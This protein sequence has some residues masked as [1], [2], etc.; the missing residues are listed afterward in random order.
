MSLL[1]TK[2][3]APWRAV[4]AICGAQTRNLSRPHRRESRDKV[5][6][7][8]RMRVLFCGRDEF[9]CASLAALYYTKTQ[10]RPH[11]VIGLPYLFHSIEV[12]F[13]QETPP[14]LA[15]QSAQGPPIKLLASQLGLRTH[16]RYRGQERNM[17]PA[18]DLIIA[19]FPFRSVPPALIRGARYGGLYLHPSMLPEFDGP[20]PFHHTLLHDHILSTGVTVEALGGAKDGNDK[21][22]NE[23]SQYLTQH[24]ASVP[25]G[26]I[27]KQLERI[28]AIKG[29]QTLLGALKERAHV[30]GRLREQNGLDP[31][32]P[33]AVAPEREIVEEFLRWE[34]DR[35]QA[36]A[37]GID[38]RELPQEMDN[39]RNVD[40][41]QQILGPLW[42]KVEDSSGNI[43]QIF[44]EDTQY[45][46]GTHIKRQPYG[47]DEKDG[48]W[49]WSHF[50]RHLEQPK[51]EGDEDKREPRFGFWWRNGDDSIY[52][53]IGPRGMGYGNDLGFGNDY[54]RI[55]RLR[56]EGREPSSAVQV[57]RPYI[58]GEPK[59]MR[60]LLLESVNNLGKTSGEPVTPNGA[61]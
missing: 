52:F 20:Y 5:T 48:N 27:P 25:S 55:R 37:S 14:Y 42:F 53:S 21:N 12:A 15:D 32:L 22:T 26:C 16:V 41:R 1:A 8:T 3:R 34:W 24:V 11:R 54:L 43:Q 10:E 7:G 50:S 57:M 31:L 13:E 59:D 39:L 46:P 58:R 35:H 38:D 19:A 28:L 33:Q 51:E 40:R 6:D 49:K 4:A 2:L 9:S 29:A 30:P 47:P 45:D 17:P 56:V 60:D 23:E 36:R 61:G 18:F 44:I